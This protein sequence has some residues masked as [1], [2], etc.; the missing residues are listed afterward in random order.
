MQEL[1]VLEAKVP[2]RT[3]VMAREPETATRLAPIAT[4]FSGP[5]FSRF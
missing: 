1:Q 2:V 3:Q 4:W 5:V